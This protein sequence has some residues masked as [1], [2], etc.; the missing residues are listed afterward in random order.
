[1]EEEKYKKDS[2]LVCRTFSMLGQEKEKEGE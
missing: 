1:M 2:Y